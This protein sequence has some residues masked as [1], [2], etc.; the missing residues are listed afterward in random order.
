MRLRKKSIASGRITTSYPHPPV[1]LWPGLLFTSAYGGFTYRG[2]INGSWKVSRK[3]TAA[4]H[5]SKEVFFLNNEVHPD[6]C[7]CEY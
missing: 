2:F 6:P 7:D 3:F 4:G 1:A 5:G